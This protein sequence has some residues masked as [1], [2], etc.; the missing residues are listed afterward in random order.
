MPWNLQFGADRDGLHQ[1][2]YSKFNASASRIALRCIRA[3]DYTET[4]YDICS[5]LVAVVPPINL[6]P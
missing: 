6:H 2:K 3:T 1:K 4:G 5:M